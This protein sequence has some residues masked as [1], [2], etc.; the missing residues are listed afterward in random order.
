VHDPQA[1]VRLDKWL[2]AARFFR[3]RPLAVEAVTGGRVRLNDARVKPSRDV[4]PGD[5]LEVTLAPGLRVVVDVRAT[6]ERR[7]SAKA[8]AELYDETEESRAARERRAEE[9]RLA[10]PPQ[11]LSGGRPEKRDRRR[12][13]AARRGE[14]RRREGRG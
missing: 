8:A 1:P 12:L 4:R 14:R 5:R 13:E 10:Q 2:W 11:P 9:R 7:V 3:T 6:V